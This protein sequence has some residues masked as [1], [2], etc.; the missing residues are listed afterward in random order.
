MASGFVTRN[1]MTKYP[2]VLDVFYDERLITLLDR[3]A[4]R[5]ALLFTVA[6]FK[7]S[8]DA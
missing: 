2:I 1:S 6:T 3:A 8:S 4:D 7:R 5:L